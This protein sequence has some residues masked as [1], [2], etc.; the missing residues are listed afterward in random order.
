M[1]ICDFYSVC[2]KIKECINN[3]PRLT[4]SFKESLNI[5]KELS[6]SLLSGKIDSEQPLTFFEMLKETVENNSRRNSK[7]GNRF[8]EKFKKLCLY[9]FLT[10]G[11]LAYETLQRNMNNG[12]PSITTLIRTLSTFKHSCEGE[13]NFD[14]LNDFLKGRKY[15]SHV[16]ISED[17]TAIVKRVRFN[18]E[19][20]QLVGSVPKLNEKTS[21]PLPDQYKANSVSNIKDIVENETL[22]NNAY[23]FMAQPLADGAPAFCLTIFGSDNR[24]RHD[25]VLNRWKFI[26]EEANK[27][28][29]KIEGFSSDGDSRCLKAMKILADLPSQQITESPYSPYFRVNIVHLLDKN[30]FRL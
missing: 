27:R 15:P 11:R 21:F 6:P 3:D 13:V 30:I 28:N 8:S 20:N 26:C 18:V 12:L 23:V 1:K 2:G 7:M 9:I 17:Q 29:I 19:T 5:V 16:F 25:D 22:A 14:H 10:S 24:F 4:T